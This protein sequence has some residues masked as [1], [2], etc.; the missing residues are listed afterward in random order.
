M[1]VSCTITED[2]EGDIN[3]NLISL[4][5][6]INYWLYQHDAFVGCNT[7]LPMQYTALFTAVKMT[8]LSG[9]VFFFLCSKQRSW[10]HVRT[11]SNEAVL[12]STHILEQK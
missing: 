7:N 4:P 3:R 12:T 6:Y 9:N 8:N 10:V 1:E 5:L 2:Q 11:A